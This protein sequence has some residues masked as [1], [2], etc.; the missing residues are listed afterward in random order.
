MSSFDLHAV[1]SYGDGSLYWKVRPT[2]RVKVGDEVGV[3]ASNGY[4]VT[5]YKGKQYMVHRLVWE[6][7]NGS[8][9]EGMEVDHKDRVR[10]NNRI[11]NLR[12]AT[13]GQNSQNHPKHGHNKLGIKNIYTRKRGN[14]LMY[15]GQLLVNGVAHRKSST[16]LLVV[17]AWLADMRSTLHGEYANNGEINN[18]F[19]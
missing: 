11:E 16:D 4:R 9:P 1:F 7:H 13:R 6:Y 17:R 8:I 3:V 19:V 15:T 12:L 14:C 5:S 2:N 18:E 10:D